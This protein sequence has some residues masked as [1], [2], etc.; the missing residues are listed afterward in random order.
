VEWKNSD[1]LEKCET[2]DMQQ[3]AAAD[4][5]QAGFELKARLCCFKSS[6]PPISML[7][8]PRAIGT[9]AHPTVRT[10]ANSMVYLTI[11]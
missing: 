3:L 10:P 1:L 11:L 5:H 4:S 6:P 2:H 8:A 9:S 7:S